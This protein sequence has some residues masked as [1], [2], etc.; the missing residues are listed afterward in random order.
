[1]IFELIT[2]KQAKADGLKRYFTGKLCVNGHAAPR[3]VET[4]ACIACAH[5][6][7]ARWR[8]N[9]PERVAEYSREYRA[10]AKV[11]IK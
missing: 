9:N 7:S 3:L 11:E 5:M 8:K 10:L 4:R 6:Y 1:M 2:R